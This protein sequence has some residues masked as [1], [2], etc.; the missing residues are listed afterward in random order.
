MDLALRDRAGLHS[1]LEGGQG[2]S[3]GTRR[4]NCELDQSPM[5]GERCDPADL[6]DLPDLAD[7]PDLGK[8][9][10]FVCRAFIR[11]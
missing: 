7:S 2:V 6:L 5:T 10:A 1:G 8:K 4:G 11:R 9:R 3:R